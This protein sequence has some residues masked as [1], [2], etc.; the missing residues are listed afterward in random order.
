L[1]SA[2]GAAFLAAA[3]AP[4][5]RAEVFLDF[6]A[7]S[8]RVEADIAT[9]PETIESTESGYH[10][11]VGA[12]RE[13]RGGGSIGVRLEADDLDSTLL[14]SLRALDYRYSFSRRFAVGA[15]L[16]AARLDLDT[17]AQG[18]YFGVGAQLKDL[19]PHW[20]LSL[21]LRYGD[22][23]ARDNLL[24]T[25]PQGGRPDDFYDLRGVSLYLSRRF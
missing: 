9:M 3:I 17:P 1:P 24:P 2:V 10:F 21:D 5:A 23:L 13:L 19:L 14:L 6:G 8:T 11:G 16:G 15:F 22:K 18:Y 4:S 12:R 7:N 25:D 20:D